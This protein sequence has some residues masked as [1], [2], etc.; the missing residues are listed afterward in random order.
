MELKIKKKYLYVVG[1]VALL[2]AVLLVLNQKSIN[3]DTEGP[4]YLR[5]NFLRLSTMNTNSCGGTFNYVEGMNENARI[6]GSCC[7]EMD[8]H[9]YVEQIKGLKKYERYEIIPSDPYDIPVKEAK[10]LLNYGKD[11]KLNEHQ[12]KTYDE[13]M[14]LSHE[15]G[16][17]CCKCWHWYAYE[18]LAKRLIIDY[19]FNSEQIAEVWDLSDACGGSGHIHRDE[20]GHN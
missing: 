15:G 7:S 18:G 4:D 10:K 2:T 16:P 19:D 8:F 11:I 13:A 5:E 1:A 14:G 20:G 17:C 3:V 12:Q 6:Q 9:R